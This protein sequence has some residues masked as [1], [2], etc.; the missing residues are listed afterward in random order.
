ML[1]AAPGS[2]GGA[3]TDGSIAQTPVTAGG[4]WGWFRPEP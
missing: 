4:R 3:V 1:P 2:T